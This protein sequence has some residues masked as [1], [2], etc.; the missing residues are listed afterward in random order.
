LIFELKYDG[1][2]ALM[3]RD[4]H[5][6]RLGSRKRNTYKSFASLCSAIAPTITQD[7]VLDGEI[8]C[9]DSEG[10]PQFNSLLY[11]RGEPCF[12]AFDILCLAGRDLRAPPLLERKSILH[13]LFDKLPARVGLMQHIDTG[14]T[15]FFAAVCERDLEGIVAK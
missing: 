3:Y 11:R 1:F 14:G 4:D 13:R 12:M 10:R 5:G 6:V 9:L 2:R 8:V 7:V 15:E